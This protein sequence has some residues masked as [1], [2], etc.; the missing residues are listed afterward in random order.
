MERL[1]NR[2]RKGYE[3]LFEFFIYKRLNIKYEDSFI[4]P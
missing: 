1:K 2:D 4:V 3:E